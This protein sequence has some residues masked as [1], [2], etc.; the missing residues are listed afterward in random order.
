M[1]DSSIRYIKKMFGV[2]EEVDIEELN[3]EN[4]ELRYEIY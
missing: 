2:E 3:K 1:I 4:K